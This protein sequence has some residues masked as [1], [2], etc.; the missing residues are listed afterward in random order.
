MSVKFK[1]EIELGNEAMQDQH[2][3]AKSL[4]GVADKLSQL[5]STRFGPYGLS[6]KILDE[7]GNSVG[8][9]EVAEEKRKDRW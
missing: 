7:N 3:V 2:D 1:L 9:W 6:G 8:R 5:Q 4:R